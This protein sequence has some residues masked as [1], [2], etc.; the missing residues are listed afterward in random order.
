[1]RRKRVSQA[2][3]AAS[4]SKRASAAGSRSMQTSV[5]VD[6]SRSATKR[7]WPPAPK[8]Q[9]TAVSPLAGAVRS[10]SSPAST[11]TWTGVMSR[12]IAK[13]LR[14]LPDCRVG[15][16]L[17]RAPALRAPDLEVI[18]NA[19]DHDLLLDPRVGEQRRRQGD[20]AA[21]VQLDLEGVAL[22]EAAQLAVLGAHRVQLPE[23]ALDDRLVR[24]GRPDRDTGLGILGENGAVGEGRAKASG[25]A[26]PV[27]RVQRMLEVA[28]KRQ[29]ACP[30]KSQTGVAEWEEPRHSGQLMGASLAH[31]LPLCNTMS[32]FSVRWGS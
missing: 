22:V 28:S 3:S 6:P 5:P 27:L 29:F 16:L 30:R 32:H 15:G 26:Q 10:I 11:G 23:R 4:S 25:D 17:D 9:S 13:A 19:H 2:T 12:R 21:R 20:A 18:P 31:F 24:V 14:H 8:V 7:A 1:M